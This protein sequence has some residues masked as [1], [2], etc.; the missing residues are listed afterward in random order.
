[1]DKEQKNKI[2]HRYRAIEKFLEHFDDGIKESATDDS[3]EKKQD[4]NEEKKTAEPTE[5]KMEIEGEKTIKENKENG[6][7]KLIEKP[8]SVGKDQKEQ[9]TPINEEKK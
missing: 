3:K 5:N 8:I 6:S 9:I 2:S 7:E 4:E 1:M